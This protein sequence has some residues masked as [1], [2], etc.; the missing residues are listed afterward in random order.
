MKFLIT[1]LKIVI[2]TAFFLL[3]FQIFNVKI[4]S[5][6]TE[7]KDWRY[8]AAAASMPLTIIPFISINRWKLFL[9]VSGIVESFFTLWHINL[10]ALFQGLIIP[11]TQGFDVLRIFYIDQRHPKHRGRAG[12]TVFIERMIGFV[13]LCLLSIVAIMSVAKLRDFQPLF[14]TIIAITV[15]VFLGLG[16]I[17][18]KTLH[19]FYTGYNFK[20]KII[21]RLFNYIE[22]F[23]GAIV[24][25]PY[26][27]VLPLSLVWIAAFQL[28]TV[29]TIYLVFCA[30][31]YD[32][33][34]VQHVAIYPVIAILSMVPITIGGF[35]V[36]EGFFVY[37]YALV[38]VPPSV[39]MG[40]SIVQ[41]II[42]I[43]VPATLGG[44]LILWEIITRRAVDISK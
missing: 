7:I 30:Y 3:L 11:S 5:L 20:N 15:A 39:A 28:A 34:F 1:A 33:P 42:L 12:S 24:Y 27:K 9:R 44:M 4:A 29:F 6:V 2:T 23:H 35:G 31:G 41:Y 22:T 18:S 37:F 19:G 36:R 25:F 21:T 32:I 14:L 13:L 17:L 43:L 40:V 26:R 10:K 8:L 16:L 38:G